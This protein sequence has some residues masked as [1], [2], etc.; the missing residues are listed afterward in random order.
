MAAADSYTMVYALAT[1][2]GKAR[3]S[4]AEIQASMAKEKEEKEGA[5]PVH[6]VEKT[7]KAANVN[8]YATDIVNEVSQ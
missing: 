1:T 4:I 7:V 2:Q 8:G 5:T 3:A 6:P